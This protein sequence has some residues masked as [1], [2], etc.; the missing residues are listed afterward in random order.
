MT[1]AKDD[2]KTTDVSWYNVSEGTFYSE[3]R[4]TYGGSTFDTVWQITD[5]AA[6]NFAHLR[7]TAT[8]AAR[9]EVR[10][11]GVTNVILATPSGIYT[12]TAFIKSA[13]ALNVNDFEHF[14]SGIRVGTGDQLGAMP[15]GTLIALHVGNNFSDA[16]QWNGHIAEL[17]YANV[18]KDNAFLQSITT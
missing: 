10:D 4:H 11:L 9:L 6:Q 2:C 1:R 18:R 15:A 16:D 12:A 8:G 3:A 13:V 14:F 17:A 5:V 7:H